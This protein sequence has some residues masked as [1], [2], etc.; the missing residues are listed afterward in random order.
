[1]LGT[2]TVEK[3]A[4]LQ[5]L[6]ENKRKHIAEYEE[7]FQVFR[8]QLIAECEMRARQIRAVAKFEDLPP[9]PT[10]FQLTVPKS[11][12]SEYNRAIAMVEWSTDDEIELSS[13]DFS[14]FVLD[15][16]DW[17]NGFAQS[18]AAYR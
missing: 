15:E 13:S 2:V 17:K 4:L 8:D 11:Y 12:E 16:W 14:A 1:M 3:G 10:F 6:Q 9:A 7:A 18:V 5:K